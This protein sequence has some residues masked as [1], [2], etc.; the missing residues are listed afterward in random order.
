[1]AL[2]NYSDL[3]KTG[4][5]TDAGF[6]FEFHCAH[7]ARQWRSPFKPFRMGQFTG[8]LSQL[9]YFFEGARRASTST[10]RLTYWRGEGARKSALADAQV[11]AA[12]I[13]TSCSH[14][15]KAYCS[16]CFNVAEG[17]CRPCLD[18]AASRSPGGS[19]GGGSAS[20]REG[21]SGPAC[22]TCGTANVG[23]RFCAECG[24]DMASTHKSCPGCGV[25]CERQTRFCADC[26]HGF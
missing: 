20:A 7:C 9:A 13:F 11:Q 12:A 25:M 22:P 14:C 24:F 21:G 15:E 3:S 5:A 8:L 10:G 2:D 19:A 23:G 16:D 17:I 18:E 4:S 1:M 26:G 6:Q